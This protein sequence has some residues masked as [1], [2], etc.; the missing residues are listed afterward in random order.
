MGSVKPGANKS[1]TCQNIIN[2]ANEFGLTR[3]Q[4]GPSRGNNVLDLYFTTNPTL[5]KN[6]ETVPGI[7]D[8]A[9]V[10]VDSDIKATYNPPAPRK[11]YQFKKANW[12]RFCQ[13]LT[14]LCNTFMENF[15]DQD[16]EQNW[17]EFKDIIQTTVE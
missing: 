10:V 16:I 11:V 14:E 8:H 1:S 4:T 6:I 5:T 15:M 7:S 12:E 17:T 9:A 13:Q 3:Q 2:I